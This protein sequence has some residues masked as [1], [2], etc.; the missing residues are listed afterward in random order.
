MRIVGGVR[1]LHGRSTAAT[2]E[3]ATEHARVEPRPDA[4]MKS[5]GRGLSAQRAPQLR[6]DLAADRDPAERLRVRRAARRDPASAA[7]V[8]LIQTGSCGGSG[9]FGAVHVKRIAVRAA[10]AHL[11][12]SEHVGRAAG[13]CAASAG[14]TVAAA[15][16]ARVATP[17]AA[18]APRPPPPIVMKKFSKMPGVRNAAN[19]L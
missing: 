10:A 2:R 5:S 6:R 15:P 1:P 13:E 17:V 16:A 8:A 12:R 19:R 7:A 3:P 9:S 11:E 14:V 4:Q 18:T